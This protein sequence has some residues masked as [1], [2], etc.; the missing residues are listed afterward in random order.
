MKSIKEFKSGSEEDRSYK[1]P[2]VVKVH[3]WL[4]R[5]SISSRDE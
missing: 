1:T 5:E 2:V 4:M 3:V